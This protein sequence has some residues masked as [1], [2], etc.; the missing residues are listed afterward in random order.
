MNTRTFICAG[1]LAGEAPSETLSNAVVIEGLCWQPELLRE[2]T[3]NADR[4]VLGL[5]RDR[6]SASEF[7]TEARRAGIDPMG[8]QIV[9]L[10]ELPPSA[11]QVALGAARARAGA[12][13]SVEPEQL[14]AVFPESMSRRSFLRGPAPSYITVPTIDP[15]SCMAGDGCRSCF[16]ACPEDAYRWN[17]RR[18]TFAKDACISCG[19]CVTACPVSAIS[20]GGL[21]SSMIR[22]SV[23][24][25][26]AES[27][28]P[29]GIAFVCTNGA[30]GGMPDGWH[31]I[32][33]QCTGMIPGT[34]VLGALMLGA[35]S[36][37]I[38]P[39]ADSGCRFGNDRRANQALD[40]ARSALTTAG[41]SVNRIPLSASGAVA[42]PSRAEPLEDPFGRL[43]PVEIVLALAADS[44][45]VAEHPGS[46]LGVVEID[47]GA[48]TA[49]MA[50]TTVCPTG[51]LTHE[52]DGSSVVIS[53]DATRCPACTQCAS[54]CPEIKR[55][56]IRVAKRS[57]SRA[58]QIGVQELHRSET[59]LCER[60]GKP[61]APKDVI[62]RI[63]TMLGPDHAGAMS[64]I[65]RRCIDCRGSW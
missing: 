55:G 24:A 59:L 30:A 7:Q 56:A 10:D 4:M 38:I 18:M 15:K 49:C 65:S 46:P 6:Y 19:I 13:G 45:L 42:N 31:Q 14:K 16:V 2:H 33:V 29:A 20:D 40:Y 1:T 5:H 35:G 52:F 63:G 41:G 57:D 51:A 43:G 58:L 28:A 39:C 3:V 17:G 26:V 44:V 21:S 64:V 36:A 12:Y 27:A 50:C 22:A 60:C 32:A 9:V 8:I 61:V 53:F 25:I 48:C 54:Y 11:M 62:E 37:T 34:W 23:E 47:P